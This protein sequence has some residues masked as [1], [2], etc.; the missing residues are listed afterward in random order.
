MNFEKN[1]L[2]VKKDWQIPDEVV[3]L[4]LSFK[5]SNLDPM[6]IVGL[7]R[8]SVVY[9]SYVEGVMELD[10]CQERYSS[11]RHD[12]PIVVSGP[13]R[14]IKSRQSPLNVSASIDGKLI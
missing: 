4:G 13:V 3:S 9:I 10:I 11:A 7:L 8:G 1:Q 2:N 14:T 6:I 12:D 5:A